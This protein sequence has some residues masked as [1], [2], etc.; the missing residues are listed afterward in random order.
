VAS[1]G[2]AD[3]IAEVGHDVTRVE[4]LTDV[5]E[6]LGGRVKTLHPKIH[7]AILARRELADDVATLEQHAIAPF[8]L[9]CV[10]LYPFEQVAGRRYVREEEAVEMIDIGGPAMLRA[11][12]KNFVNVAPVCSPE[13]YGS[14]LEELRTSRDISLMTRRALAAEAFAH[15]AAYEATIANWF[16][17]RE[18]FPPRLIVSLEKSVDLPYGENPHQRAAYYV[19][20]GARRH[21]LSRVEQRGG[22][23]LSFN[24]L[25]DLDAARGLLQEFA[26]P[27]CVIVKHGNPCGCG[28]ASTIEEA[29]Q[30]ALAADPISAYGGIVAL[31]RRVERPLAE[32]LAAQ[33][34]EVLI[35]PGYDREGLELLREKPATRILDENERR[36]ATPG[37]RDYRRVLGGMLVQD[38][39]TDVD[40]REGMGVVTKAAPDETLWG[41]LLFA[42]RVC[43]HVA[44][45]SIVVAKGLQTIGV[46]AG[47]MSRVDAVRIALEKTRALG[48]DPKDAVLASDAFFPFPDG[49]ELALTA[50]VR[51]IIQPG[52]SKRD[53]EVI[54]AAEEAGATM[55]FTDRRHFRH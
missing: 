16:A 11:A 13:R 30:K 34:V 17:E 23:Q 46:G 28:M 36:G 12:A 31:N 1:G 10:N 2:T 55:I 8:H 15:T 19:E 42:W 14:I 18:T 20:A 45:N 40:D 6:L 37:E 33:F 38:A 7:A 5:P 35:A 39:D 53:N 48:H 27:T 49:P 9:V 54:A 4:E 50:G 29:Y 21:L 25:G 44:S 41:D 24:N 51:A 43:K 3:A 26:M 52:G 22:R 47:Q 32:L